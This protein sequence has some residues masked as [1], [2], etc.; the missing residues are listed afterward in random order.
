M[1]R[2]GKDKKLS[3]SVSVYVQLLKTKDTLSLE[4]IVAERRQ[5]KEEDIE[6]LMLQLLRLLTQ[7]RM[8]QLLALHVELRDLQVDLES[9][10]LKLICI[11]F[12]KDD[13]S[14]ATKDSF[15]KVMKKLAQLSTGKALKRRI[16]KLGEDNELDCEERMLVQQLVKVCK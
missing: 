2:L 4:Q 3:S 10:S 13:N 14:E 7:L 1:P 8:Q 9:M 15:F 16:Q 6:R 12:V 5:L 11:R